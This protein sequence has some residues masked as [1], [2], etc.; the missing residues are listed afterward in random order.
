[1]QSI[2]VVQERKA[3]RRSFALCNSCFWS[4]TLFSE[5][6]SLACPSCSDGS[7]SLIPL[8]LDE[9][10]RLKLSP[11]SGVEISFSRVRA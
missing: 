3:G 1:M 10:Y 5:T 2:N 4:A 8:A 9:Q 6:G 7:V 11:A